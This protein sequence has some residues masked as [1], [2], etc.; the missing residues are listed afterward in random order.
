[1][2]NYK[3]YLP[4]PEF[5][6]ENIVLQPRG[7]QMNDALEASGKHDHFYFRSALICCSCAVEKAEGAKLA[8]A[9]VG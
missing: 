5:G 7:A 6:L 3:N 2:F 1:M 9:T 4:F 8:D